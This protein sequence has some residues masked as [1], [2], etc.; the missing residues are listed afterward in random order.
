MHIMCPAHVTT[1][2]VIG[3]LGAWHCCAG[4]DLI[5]ESMAWNKTTSK[6]VHGL[7]IKICSRAD[8]MS[9]G[10]PCLNLIFLV[11]ISYQFRDNAWDRAANLTL[12][13]LTCTYSKY[14]AL[15]HLPSALIVSEVARPFFKGVEILQKSLRTLYTMP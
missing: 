11:F 6:L 7:Y 12:E 3:F 10:S 8:A 13:T 2:L 1:Q 15:S 9:E 4:L 14:A 5:L